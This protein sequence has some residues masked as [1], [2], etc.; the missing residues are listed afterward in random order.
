SLDR[1]AADGERRGAS[2]VRPPLEPDG[3]EELLVDPAGALRE[4]VVIH[5]LREDVLVQRVADDAPNARHLLEVRL[6]V[7]QIRP[8]V[9][10]CLERVTE[11]LRA[12]RGPDYVRERR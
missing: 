8:R 9:A 4:P 7:D 5:V 3:S 2:E 11:T 1:G 10:N 6:L 12:D